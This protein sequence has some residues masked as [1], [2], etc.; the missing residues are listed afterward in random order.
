MTQIFGTRQDPKLELVL[1]SLD[2][3]LL[4]TP[5]LKLVSKLQT[6]VLHPICKLDGIELHWNMDILLDVRDG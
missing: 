3:M 6:I 5:H 4:S 2:E 1:D